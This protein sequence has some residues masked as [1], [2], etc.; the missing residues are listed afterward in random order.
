MPAVLELCTLYMVSTNII[1]LL[2]LTISSVPC[3]HKYICIASHMMMNLYF[4]FRCFFHSPFN[5]NSIRSYF[6]TCRRS[7]CTSGVCVM[8]AS[9]CKTLKTMVLLNSFSITLK[10]F[11]RSCSTWRVMWIVCSWRRYEILIRIF[12]WNYYLSHIM[13]RHASTLLLTNLWVGLRCIIIIII[14][15]VRS[16]ESNWIDTDVGNLLLAAAARV[17]RLQ[18]YLSLSLPL[19]FVLNF[20]NNIWTVLLR[21]FPYKNNYAL[22]WLAAQ[23]Y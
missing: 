22:L 8:C 2:L 18:F 14:N 15:I 17:C 3:C 19:L 7:V 1:L 9:A 21:F 13:Q 23:Y 16:I 4:L 12:F 5:S 6:R 10:L 20:N 11:W